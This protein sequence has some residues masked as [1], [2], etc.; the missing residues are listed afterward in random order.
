MDVLLTGANGYIGLHILR[1]LL[2]HEYSVVAAVQDEAHSKDAKRVGSRHAKERLQLVYVPDM[3]ADG[4]FDQV[5]KDHKISAVIHTGTADTVVSELSEHAIHPIVRGMENL[6]KSIYEHAPQV[7]KFIYTSSVYTA[8]NDK[9]TGGHVF[10]TENDWAYTKLSEATPDH[11]LSYVYV[12]K[13]MSERVL[14][15][16]V[17]KNTPNF[18]VVSVNAALCCGPPLQKVS[19]LED[20]NESLQ[21]FWKLCTGKIP[22]DTMGEYID[23]RECA[24]VHVTALRPEFKQKRWLVF[25]EDFVAKKFVEISRMAEPDENVNTGALL[26]GK[27]KID[28]STFLNDTKMKFRSLR[29]TINDTISVFRA[30][31]LIQDSEGDGDSDVIVP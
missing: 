26:K 21:V 18:D 11:P 17:Q 22:Q 15:D 14:W 8:V 23:V 5:F 27:P 10:F 30:Y 31:G 1:C 25:K 20:L 12:A 6:L 24:L 2:E 7:V 3:M 4:A 13:S 29:D 19:K 16:F 9:T 28:A